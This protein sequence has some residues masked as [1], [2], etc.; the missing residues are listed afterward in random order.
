MKKFKDANIPPKITTVIMPQLQM[1]KGGKK[2]AHI[3]ILSMTSES[4]KKKVATKEV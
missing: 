2:Y 1:G 3:T 4:N